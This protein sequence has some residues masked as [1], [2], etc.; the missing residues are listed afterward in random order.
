MM[1]NTAFEA[2]GFDRHPLHVAHE[3]GPLTENAS[4]RKFD[5]PPILHINIKNRLRPWT[6]VK[7]AQCEL[8]QT[9]LAQL[10]ENVNPEVDRHRYHCHYDKQD[11]EQWRYFCFSTPDPIK[12]NSI[13]H[14]DDDGSDDKSSPKKVDHGLLLTLQCSFDSKTV[15]DS[16][17]AYLSICQYYIYVRH[18]RAQAA[19]VENAHLRG[20]NLPFRSRRG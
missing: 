4:T 13:G 3:L 9:C 7:P 18:K 10:P 11:H 14:C 12:N 6:L 5:I 16:L 20:V 2:C 19:D 17:V 8:R 15:S 1:T